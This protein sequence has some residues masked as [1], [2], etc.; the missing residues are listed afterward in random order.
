M[1][2]IVFLG[3]KQIGIDCLQQLVTLQKSGIVDIIAV[4]GNNRISKPDGHSVESIAVENNIPVLTDLQDLPYCDVLIS[5]QFN[6]IL[7]KEHIQK[8]TLAVNLHMA[9]LPEYRGCNQFSFA[10]IDNATTFGTTLHIIDEQI[11]HGDILFEKRFSVPADCWVEDLYN[12]T[13]KASK[14]LLT[15]NLLLL[16]QG[17]YST[18]P[19]SHLEQ[20]RGTQLHY[21]KEINDIKKIDLNWDAEK[22]ARH[23]RATYM[24]NFEPPYCIINQEKIYFTK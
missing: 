19:Q 22:I 3:G 18:I 1:K 10:I 16:I 15:E 20:A 6:T 17:N 23:I 12:L 24:P 9:P 8:A 5:V 14:E 21:R 13:Y 2:K 4:F 11:D 7:Q